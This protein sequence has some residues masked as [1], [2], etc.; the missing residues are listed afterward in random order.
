MCWLKM[1]AELSAN[2]VISVSA[3]EFIHVSASGSSTATHESYLSPPGCLSFEEANWK[4][5]VCLIWDTY[6]SRRC[7]LWAQLGNMSLFTTYI[8]SIEAG[9]TLVGGV[10]S[11]PTWLLNRES[12]ICALTVCT[13]YVCSTSFTVKISCITATLRHFAQGVSRQRF[14]PIVRRGASCNQSW[15]FGG[16]RRNCQEAWA[17]VT[18]PA[19]CDSACPPKQK[20][21]DVRSCC[22]TQ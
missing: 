9:Q 15:L 22:I 17:V 13:V 10:F 11:I 5:A 16:T 2:T 7:N 21:T 4:T 1:T 19:C 3:Y 6:R 12:D 8:L 14:T 18:D 20:A